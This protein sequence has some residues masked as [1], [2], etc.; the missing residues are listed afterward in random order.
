MSP[1]IP[2]IDSVVYSLSSS[3]IVS[4]CSWR[5]VSTVILSADSIF[6]S[7]DLFADFSSEFADLFA[8]SMLIFNSSDI[9]AANLLAF[10]LAGCTILLTSANRET[11]FVHLLDIR[12]LSY[13]FIMRIDMLKNSL[14]VCFQTIK[15]TVRYFLKQNIPDQNIDRCPGL[16]L[17]CPVIHTGDSFFY[18]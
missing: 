17:I 18:L 4:I 14:S 8:D 12:I 6:E 15:H 1:V 5:L 16:L 3:I 9:N 11:A 13:A 10:S 7:A 2:A